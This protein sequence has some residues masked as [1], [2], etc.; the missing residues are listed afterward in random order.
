MIEFLVRFGIVK[1]IISLLATT[2]SLFSTIITAAATVVIAIFTIG[3]WLV[4]KQQNKIL[5]SHA[6][7]MRENSQISDKQTEILNSQLELQRMLAR[8]EY[9]PAV[10][11]N[12][13]PGGVNWNW[14][15]I[16]AELINRGRGTAYEIE[17]CGYRVVL[18]T[19]ESEFCQVLTDKPSLSPG[20]TMK[21]REL[22]PELVNHHSET[23][24]LVIHCKDFLGNLWHTT[25]NIHPQMKKLSE[26]GGQVIWDEARWKDLPKETQVFCKLCAPK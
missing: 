20:E 6:A 21:T 17:L 25:I 24:V 23:S 7:I 2:M 10:V 26:Q 19:G 15:S 4:Y 5:S 18:S 12:W 3:V 22:R 1:S 13:G 11:P 14:H 9:A 8:L 16:G